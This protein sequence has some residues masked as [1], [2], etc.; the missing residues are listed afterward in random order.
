MSFSNCVI[1]MIGGSLGTL[2]RYLVSILALPLSRELPLGT[3]A[4]NVTGSFIIGFFGTLTL[5]HGRFP[6]SENIRLFV[7]VGLCG[8]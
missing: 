8:G 2:A 3:I 5:V 1:I 7:M 6:V 4:T